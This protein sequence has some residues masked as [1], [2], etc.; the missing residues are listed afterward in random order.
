MEINIEVDIDILKKTTKPLSQKPMLQPKLPPGAPQETAIQTIKTLLQTHGITIN[1]QMLNL[2]KEMLANNI[3]LENS[4]LQKAKQL[5][6]LF[7][8]NSAKGDVGQTAT[9]PQPLPAPATQP[10][11]LPTQTLE[12]QAQPPQPHT[13][14]QTA[15]PDN[16]SKSIFVLKN[17]IP[18]N[19]ATAAVVDNI[20]AGQGSLSNLFEA[21]SQG[22][23]NIE[24]PPL[25]QNLLN[26]LLTENPIQQQGSTLAETALRE[27]LMKDGVIKDAAPKES[28]VN[29]NETVQ[30]GTTINEAAPRGM[31]ANET[32]PR[33]TTV[34]GTAQNET[35]QKEFAQR[36]IQIREATT[37][38]ITA[39]EALVTKT[40]QPT[41]L[42]EQTPQHHTPVAPAAT[43]PGNI[44]QSL[45]QLYS[46]NLNEPK[47]QIDTTIVRLAQNIKQALQTVGESLVQ[48]PQLSAQNNQ[49]TAVRN[50]LLQISATIDF[51]H[52]LQ[53]IVYL[54]LP[55]FI[56]QN[57]SDGELYIFKEKKGS[58]KKDGDAS[59]LLSLNTAYLGKIEAYIQRAKGHIILQFRLE[60]TE[61]ETLIKQNLPLLE[62]LLKV[63]SVAFVPLEKPF[64]IITTTQE[65][66][67]DV[68]LEKYNVDVRA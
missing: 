43:T 60:Q 39:R 11:P 50:I 45:L 33:G 52:N 47:S 15:T 62:G 40:A 66:L 59:A 65:I 22:L 7:N 31:I 49:L 19:Q 8:M 41:A 48:N 10:P 5:L 44:T 42:A 21:L 18:I 58:K 2:V 25:K 56:N 13:T 55:L 26:I 6:Q 24:N 46:L 30:K 68:D 64:N 34:S 37:K 67:Q 61:T 27:N 36:E 29:T 28:T 63:S 14:V 4:N 38:D 9:S 12:P 20:A 35:I 16:T 1:D 32:A 54:P 17:Q 57:R 53:D 3:S 51:V 23:A